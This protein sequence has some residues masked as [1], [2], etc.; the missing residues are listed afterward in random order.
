MELTPMF[1]DMELSY[2][3]KICSCINNSRYALDHDVISRF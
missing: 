2:G 3:F 1:F